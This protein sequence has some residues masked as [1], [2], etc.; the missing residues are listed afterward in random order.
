MAVVT[1]YQHVNQHLKQVTSQ[2]FALTKGYFEVLH[3]D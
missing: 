1:L 3:V 2:E